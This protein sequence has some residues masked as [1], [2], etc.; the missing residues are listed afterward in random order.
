MSRFDTLLVGLCLEPCQASN[1][2]LL[3]KD[4]ILDDWLRFEYIYKDGQVHERKCSK[5]GEFTF[6]YLDI[7]SML[8]EKKWNF[9]KH[10]YVL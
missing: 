3:V 10:E 1:M 7:H 5:Q 6:T 2:E 4:S 9:L 8:V